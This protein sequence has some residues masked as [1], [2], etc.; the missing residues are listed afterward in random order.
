MPGGFMWRPTTAQLD[1]INREIELA[2]KANQSRAENAR[3]REHEI[4]LRRDDARAKRR[5]HQMRRARK[6]KT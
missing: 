5:Q 2:R 1:E 3:L 4:G 6:V